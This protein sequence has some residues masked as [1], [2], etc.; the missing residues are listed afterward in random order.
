MIPN[1][2]NSFADID[3]QL[4]IL[5]LEKQIYKQRIKLSLNSSK[6]SFTATNIKTE[7]KGLLQERLLVFLKNYL[8]QKLKGHKKDDIL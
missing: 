8:F 7:F 1:S 3:H 2:Y 6:N 5:S 4:K